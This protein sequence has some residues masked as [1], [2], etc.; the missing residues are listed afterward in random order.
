M[1]SARPSAGTAQHI[2]TPAN[3]AARAFAQ[4]GIH[5]GLGH[6]LRNRFFANRPALAHA[7]FRG[8]F[9]QFPLRH[10]RHFVPIVVVGFIG[11]LFWPYAY[12]DF[13][14]YTFYPY[15][16]DAFWPY[17]YNDVYNGIIGVYGSGKGPA[18]GGSGTGSAYAATTGRPQVP[19]A[20]LARDV[21]ARSIRS[22]GTLAIP[23][24]R[25]LHSSVR[26]RRRSGSF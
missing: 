21:T 7:I 25:S 14:D 13:L 15:A 24:A 1:G 11:P 16:Y 20:G 5:S 6:I 23:D 3:Q 26:S 22:M 10:H 2:A 9:A 17:A 8:R 12:D 18:H 19:T 4:A